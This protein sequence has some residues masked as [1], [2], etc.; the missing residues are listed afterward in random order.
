VILFRRNIEAAQ[1]VH[2]LL[3]AAKQ[4]VDGSLLGCADLEGGSVDRLRDLVAP[5]P[6]AFAVASTHKPTLFEK[7]GRLIGQELR[8]LGLKTPL[9]PVLDLRTAASEPVMT[10]RVVSAAPAEVIT[11]ARHFLRGLAQA[12]GLGCGKHFPGLGSGQVDSHHSTP[13]IDRSFASLW[14]DDLLPYRELVKR[15]PM[16]TVSHAAYPDSASG[17]EPAS[18]SR[19][20]ITEILARKIGY[21]GLILS[22]DMEMGGILTYMGMAEAAVRSIGAGMHVLEICR[23]PALVLAAYE[24]LLREAESSPAFARILRRAATKVEAF[25][26]LHLKRD[27]LPRPPTNGAV[28][29]MRTAV[30]HFALQVAKAGQA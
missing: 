19:Y 20:W 15:L 11:Y 2:A 23:D 13:H 29:K 22:D 12:G 16:V 7:H 3:A 26:A 14:R 1:Q 6:S 21:Q 18:I 9:A 30:E 24:A 5:M 25:H 4:A 17:M 27:L 28:K 8:L 10:S